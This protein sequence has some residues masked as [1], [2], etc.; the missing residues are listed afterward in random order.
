MFEDGGS[1]PETARHGASRKVSRGI[2]RAIELNQLTPGQRLVET[3]LAAQY[4][5][6]RNAVREAIQWL[7]A[8]G[9]IDITRFRSAAIRRLDRAET[10][11]VLDVARALIA[12]LARDAAR[13][14][15]AALHGP[16]LDA[17][18]HDLEQADDEH[19]PGA[20]ARAR[21]HFYGVMLD[22]SQNRE[23]R[24]LFPALGMQILH[25]QYRAAGSRRL[26][27]DDFRA[28]AAAITDDDADGAEAAGRAYVDHLTTT[29]LAQLEG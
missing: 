13:H 29:T 10:I 17:A 5:V 19:V 14:F 6:G 7:A 25:A 1:A 11:A 2:M 24:R 9:I 21:R 22:I 15:D 23:L 27:L 16:R 3:D 8:R 12:I 26:R 20:F 28:L 4:G 18:L